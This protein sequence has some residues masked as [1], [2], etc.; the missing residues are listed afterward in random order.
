[1][2]FLF[3]KQSQSRIQCAESKQNYNAWVSTVTEWAGDMGGH[4]NYWW[5]WI[6]T[7]NNTLQ[8]VCPS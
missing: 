1:M 5:L 4:I 8:W 3:Y 7:S 6:P 2:A